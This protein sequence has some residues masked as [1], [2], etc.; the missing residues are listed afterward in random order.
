M[1]KSGSG[2]S[3]LAKLIAGLYKPHSGTISYGGYK[4][5]DIPNDVF[6]KSVAMVDQEIILFNSSV[7]DNIS[8]WDRR[9]T[10]EEIQKAAKTAR[11]HEWI[12]RLQNGYEYRIAENGKN[13]SGGEKAR[14][15]IARA[16]ATE[17]SFIILDEA[18]AAL[19]P[20]LE[21]EILGDIRSQCDAGIIIS[22]RISSIQNCD[23]IIVFDKGK[24]VARGTHN[25]LMENSV[26][27]EMVA[28]EAVS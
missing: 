18:S 12:I 1:G 11:I 7:A 14:I 24:P 13:I 20:L 21:R 27:R 8:F 28:E 19:D 25:E 22:H 23:E 9:I 15:E 6:S 16:L 4:I 17:P 3:T 5:E 26:Y 10:D 2:K